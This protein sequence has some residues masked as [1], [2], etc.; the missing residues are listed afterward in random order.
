M[1]IVAPHVGAWIEICFMSF[2]AIRVLVAPH[3]GAWIEIFIYFNQNFIIYVAPHVGAWIEIKA[4]E[5]LP[6]MWLSRT[7]RRCVD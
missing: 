1:A 7:S 5:K 2:R 3:V 4:L 6:L